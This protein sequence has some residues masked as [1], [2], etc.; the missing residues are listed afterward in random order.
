M[1]YKIKILALIMLVLISMPV[2]ADNSNNTNMP[3]SNDE[4]TSSGSG[5]GTT[6]IATP[7]TSSDQGNSAEI[8]TTLT[9]ELTFEH[10]DEEYKVKAGETLR[11]KFSVQGDGKEMIKVHAEG[12]PGGAK[13]E[14]YPEPG[15]TT[16]V[17][18]FTP[19]QGNSGEHIFYFRA[20]TSMGR[21][22]EAKTRVNVAGEYVYKDTPYFKDMKGQY[23]FNQKQPIEIEFYVV[24]NPEKGLMAV[25][26][27]ET[28]T[29][30]EN[31]TVSHSDFLPEGMLYATQVSPGITK[32]KVW[33]EEDHVKQGKYEIT[34]EAKAS[35]EYKNQATM[36]LTVKKFNETVQYYCSEQ[37]NCEMIWELKKKISELEERIKRLEEMLFKG[38][39][40]PASGNTS[41]ST[42]TARPT[43][44]SDGVTIGK[45]EVVRPT[46]ANST[47]SIEDGK[48]VS[49]TST[50]THEI[51]YFEIEYKI[52]QDIPNVTSIKITPQ[53]TST[54]TVYHIEAEKNSWLP[55]FKDKEYREYSSEEFSST[56]TGTTIKNEAPKPEFVMPSNETEKEKFKD[57]STENK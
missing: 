56:S 5:S 39:P 25:Y 31:G 28:T 46:E 21:K 16:V 53:S 49:N 1:N 18:E 22:A 34:W 41:T 40:W 37:T 2:M 44:T 32:V 9:R 10:L 52:S 55:F 57:T 27:T 38:S 23:E 30:T 17:I 24:G 36:N 43:A 33:W 26:P 12:L 50:G 42:S 14:N 47:V 48:V 13:V 7:S 15:N 20:E 4:T 45:V 35:E 54:G 29:Y 51:P 6:N 8:A 19:N 11:I 3:Y